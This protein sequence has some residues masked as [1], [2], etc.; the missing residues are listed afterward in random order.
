MVLAILNALVAIPKIA[1]YIEDLAA[2]ITSWWVARQTS[3]TLAAIA[4]AADLAASATT[5]EQRYAAAQA[6]QTALSRPRV[7]VS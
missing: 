2:A 7:T 6:W 5:Q 3:Q 4:N 1:G